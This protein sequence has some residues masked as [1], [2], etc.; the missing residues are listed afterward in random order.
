[1]ACILFGIIPAWG[2]INPT[3]AIAQQL[4]EKGHTVAYACHPEMA[5]ALER[6]GLDLLG[7]FRWGDRMVEI[8]KD[9]GTQ[10]NRWAVVVH[11]AGGSP[12]RLY[13]NA[14]NL[15]EQDR[16]KSDLSS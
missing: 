6:A 8:Q 16:A 2:H 10:Q 9:V 12:T 11:G 4:Q 5:P 13:F 1:V 7:T 14:R 15:Y 3:I